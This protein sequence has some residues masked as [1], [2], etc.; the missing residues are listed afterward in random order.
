MESI[1]SGAGH[2][3]RTGAD[4]T[5]P[6]AS[7]W[8]AV[9][10]RAASCAWTDGASEAYIDVQMRRWVVLADDY[11]IDAF[12]VDAP[13][14]RTIDW[15]WHERGQFAGG[16]EPASGALSG[17]CGYDELRDVRRMVGA[18][19]GAVAA[20]SS[21]PAGSPLTWEFDDA[22]VDAWL[23]PAEE[24]LYLAS[25]PGN[26]AADRHDLLVRRR[27]ARTTVF[28]AVVAPG[29][30]AAAVSN[31]TWE[32]TAGGWSLTVTVGPGRQTWSI[33]PEGIAA[34]E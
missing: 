27:V 28:A 26:P 9:V 2:A 17:T 7:A 8:P 23:A 11:L 15:L 33:G 5:W 34:R 19:A 29:G 3:S 32:P 4:V 6:N 30:R 18:G 1:D 31:V 14:P 10:E 24:E 21:L 20:S 25:A 12:A 22:R 16:T 13:A